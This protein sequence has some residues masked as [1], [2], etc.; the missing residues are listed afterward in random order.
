VKK[1][2]NGFTALHNSVNFTPAYFLRDV[3][4][5]FF[6]AFF[7]DAGAFDSIAAC[8]DANLAIGT[9]NGEQLT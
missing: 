9:L 2:A 3:F 5:A 4:L 8:A 6:L 1:A 7:F